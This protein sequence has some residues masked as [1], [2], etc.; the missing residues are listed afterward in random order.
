MHPP[1]RLLR[2][3]RR[4]RQTV[5][6]RRVG[7]DAA[8]RP[9]ETPLPGVCRR[10]LR[11]AGRIR[12]RV[13]RVVLHRPFR[14]QSAD[15]R[16]VR[17]P[18]PCRGGAA[19]RPARKP[20]GGP[21]HPAGQDDVPR[22][23]GRRFDRLGQCLRQ[24]GPGPHRVAQRLLPG[25]RQRCRDVHRQG[26]AGALDGRL[27]LYEHGRRDV[28]RVVVLRLRQFALRHGEIPLV[29]P[30]HRLPS[31]RYQ[32]V[33]RRRLLRRCRVPSGLPS[34]ADRRDFHPRGEGRGAVQGVGD[35]EE[36][37]FCGPRQSAR[38]RTG[39]RVGRR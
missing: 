4:E 5:G 39:V 7:R 23:L 25:R 12:G 3:R 34:G 38:C 31:G 32:G 16:G 14:V 19:R 10:D 8:H 24:D 26:R 17:A 15:R 1:F 29:L 21:A 9:A 20:H 11:A 33:A 36:C 22:T 30:E 27:A 37:R 13:G 2:F 35:A 28:R 18:L 6:R